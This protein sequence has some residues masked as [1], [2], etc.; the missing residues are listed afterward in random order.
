M[1]RHSRA[2]GLK[3]IIKLKSDIVTVLPQMHFDILKRIYIEEQC[4]EIFDL[5]FFHEWKLWNPSG[6]LINRLNQFFLQIRFCED[7]QSFCQGSS[8]SNKNVGF[9][10]YSTP[11]DSFLFYIPFKFKE[12][13]EQ[14]KLLQKNSAQCQSLLDLRKIVDSAQCSQFCFFEKHSNFLKN[15]FDCTQ[16]QPILD[17][18]TFQFL[19]P[20]SVS[21]RGVQLCAVSLISRIFSRKRIFQQNHSCLSRAQMAS[22]HEIKK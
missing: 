4:H 19:T 10:L 13:P 20:R 8:I 9:C 2:Q 15:Q 22:I 11:K 21:L 18:R 17:L 3:Q 6:P 1:Y 12:R 14:T 5:Y 7:I 16:C